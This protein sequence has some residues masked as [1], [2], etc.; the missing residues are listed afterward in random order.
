M[1]EKENT[2]I[3]ALGG[4]SIWSSDLKNLL[5]FYRDKVGL[6]VQIDSPEFVLFGNPGEPA[7][8]LGT[9][10]EVKGKATDPYRIMVGFITTDIQA[11]AARMKSAGVDFMENKLLWHY[12]T[13]D[14]EQLAAAIKQLQ[15]A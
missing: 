11:D 9:H 13:P 1:H 7:L 10:S 8:G 4:A 2:V 12:K 6:K 15:A 3:T 14:K 5:P